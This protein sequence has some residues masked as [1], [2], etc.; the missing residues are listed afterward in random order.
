MPTG[1]ARGGGRNTSASSEVA[2]EAVERP[3][4]VVSGRGA[5]F[6]TPLLPGLVVPGG[7]FGEPSFGPALEPLSVVAPP[8]NVT[9][10]AEQ[11]ERGLGSGMISGSCHLP[12]RPGAPSAFRDGGE[13][14]VPV[15]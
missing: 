2:E 6:G 7:C 12:L 1:R 14:L 8:G 15:R 11:L 5:G 9:C 13:K 4:R 10:L 3:G